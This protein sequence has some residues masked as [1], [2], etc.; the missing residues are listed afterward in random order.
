MFPK[1]TAPSD[2]A[3]V[4]R[5]V[6]V[7]GGTAFVGRAVVGEALAAGHRVTLFNRGITNPDLFPQ[8]EKLRGD[9]AAD[10]SPLADRTWDAVID[11]AAYHQDVVRRSVEVLAEQ[12]ERYLFVSTLSVYVDHSTTDGQRE[13]AP[14]LDV[15][16]VT[17]PA[18]LYG[19][20]KA[21][22][23]RVV[24]EALGSRA[25]VARAGLIV[26][27]N[28]P[29]NRF[30]Y[31]PRRMATGGRVLAPGHPANPL[32]FIDVRDLAAWLLRAA[33]V[34]L[35]GTFN[36]A[37]QPTPF[38]RLLDA[39]R[40]PG[41]DAELVWI[42]SQDLLEAGIDPWMGVPLWIA[43]PGWDAANA[44]DITRAI[45]AGLTHRALSDTITGALA[46][47]GDNGQSPLSAED[48]E[49]LLTRFA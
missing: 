48:E 19:A 27:P 6:L 29:T 37:G 47:P 28:D 31:W 39:C 11:V 35:P 15:D 17:D 26:G 23:E 32:Q 21:A 43:A 3:G 18:E 9:R 7:L 22:C 38:S 25:T 24:L 36:V 1:S 13:G 45:D 30:V 44:V 16:S 20:H 34:G 42:S 8:V 46:H 5:R 41:V 12:V 49:T 2:H 14:V 40:V 33:V 4:P 10:L